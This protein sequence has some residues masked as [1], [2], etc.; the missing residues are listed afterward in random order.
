M[1][2]QIILKNLA[3]DRLEIYAEG[4]HLDASTE[5]RGRDG[6]SSCRCTGNPERQ[7]NFPIGV[8]NLPKTYCGCWGRVTLSAGRS[9]QPPGP[10]WNLV[11]HDSGSR[12]VREPYLGRESTGRSR[13]NRTGGRG[14]GATD[15]SAATWPCPGRGKGV[16]RNTGISTPLRHHD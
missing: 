4:K 1:G 3:A 15:R 13:H 9:C 14:E 12:C 8:P 16:R 5:V 2:S 10:D 7:Q 11:S 6:N